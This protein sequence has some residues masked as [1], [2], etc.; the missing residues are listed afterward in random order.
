MDWNID[1]VKLWNT[2]PPGVCVDDW[3]TDWLLDCVSA[4]ADSNV[5]NDIDIVAAIIA[6]IPNSNFVFIN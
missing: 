1:C 2:D 6:I 5:N 3:L 4:E